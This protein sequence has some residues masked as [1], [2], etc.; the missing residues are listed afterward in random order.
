MPVAKVL[1]LVVLL[2]SAASDSSP[3][4]FKDAVLQGSSEYMYEPDLSD[5][6]TEAALT[7]GAFI[8]IWGGGRWMIKSRQPTKAKGTKCVTSVNH[9][10]TSK[11]QKPCLSPCDRPAEVPREADK[12][13]SPVRAPRA[14]RLPTSASRKRSAVAQE[15]DLLATFI[16][17]SEVSSL[18]EMLLA[19]VGRC[20]MNCE[21]QIAQNRLASCLIAVLRACAAKKYFQHALDAFDVVADRLENASGD[22]WSLLLWCA[23]EA[24]ECHRCSRFFERLCDVAQPSRYDIVN[25][26]HYC[27]NLHDA[28]ELSKKLKLVHDQGCKL[29]AFARNRALAIC[30]AKG[31]MDLAE[32]LR[33]CAKEVP[34]DTIAYNTLMKG[35]AHIRQ[36]Q[37]CLQLYREMRGQSLI[38]S[39]VTFGILLDACVDA[40]E[41]DHARTVFYDLQSL[42]FKVNV[43]LCTTFIKGLAAAGNITEALDVLTQMEQTGDCRPDVV[44][45]ATVA[46]GYAQSGDI[47]GGVLLIE[48]M[49]DQGVQPDAAVFHTVLGACS[50]KAIPPEESMHHFE[51]LVNRGMRPSL[52]ALSILLKSFARSRAWKDGLL[53]LEGAHKNYRLNADARLYVQLARASVEDVDGSFTLEVY[54]SMLRVFASSGLS[55]DRSTSLRLARLCSQ[56][57]EGATSTQ[58]HTEVC[59]TNGFITLESIADIV[60]QCAS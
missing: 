51:R 9:G 60:S 34:M 11:L 55:V 15:T 10:S 43:V 13:S 17:N 8:A 28:D 7:L 48:R 45:Y 29:D 2:P 19:A 36:G 40:G 44:T 25:L 30:T 58:L 3:T 50:S 23:V 54:V 27:V 32:V 14:D 35:Y 39:E 22:A 1:P 59:R 6:F 53:L 4:P 21:P 56:V 47:Q 31:S 26:V 33:E 37:R 18:P 5:S 12:Q 16:R 46:K 20:T 52:S 41:L 24:N 38:P 57:G 42:G 49:T